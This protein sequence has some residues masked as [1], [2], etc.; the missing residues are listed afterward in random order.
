MGQKALWDYA[1]QGISF[2]AASGRITVF[3]TT[4]EVLN[5]PKYFRFLYNPDEAQFAVQ[6]CNWN[7]PGV[8][9][10]PAEKVQDCLEIKCLQLVRFVFKNCNWDPDYTY[11][12]SGV[13]V[14]GQ[15][16]VAFDLR[17]FWRVK[18]GLLEVNE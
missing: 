15:K 4:L 8:H 12:I 17:D 16:L 11:R 3:K 1:E 14:P 2:S 5:Y 7:S 10:R 13:L 18:D 6:I 9:R